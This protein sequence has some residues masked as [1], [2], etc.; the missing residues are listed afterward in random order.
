LGA[1]LANRQ[2]DGR[3]P[4]LVGGQLGEPHDR[5][6]GQERRPVSGFPRCR[7]VAGAKAAADVGGF[8]VVLEATGVA[9]VMVDTMSLLGRNGVA[10]LLGIDGPPRDVTIDGRVLGIDAILQ[11]RASSAA[12][13]PTE[14]TR[15][16]PSTPSTRRVAGGRR[17]SSRSSG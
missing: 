5:S 15:R 7:I 17:R 2:R 8:D 3:P 16:P 6:R 9:R 1:T 11:N 10:C 12:S 13:T 14:K 4:P